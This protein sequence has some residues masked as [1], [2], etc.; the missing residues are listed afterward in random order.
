MMTREPLTAAKMLEF[1]IQRQ[2]YC[3]VLTMYTMVAKTYRDHGYGMVDRPFLL[4]V[5]LG[6]ECGVTEEEWLHAIRTR[7]PDGTP[8]PEY[9][10]VPDYRFD[11][12]GRPVRATTEDSDQ[13]PAT[14]GDS[15]DRAAE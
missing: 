13:S 9:P 8:I 3:S 4:L 7:V 6:K 12:T 2:M 15:V 10:P 11:P 14:T 1:F 5:E